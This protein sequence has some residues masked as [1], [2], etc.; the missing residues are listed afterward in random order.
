MIMYSEAQE[1]AVL[2]LL[3]RNLQKDSKMLQVMG[4]LK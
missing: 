1:P 2:I 4:E 3:K